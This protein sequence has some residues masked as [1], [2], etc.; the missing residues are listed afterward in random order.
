ME[1]ETQTGTQEEEQPTVQEVPTIQLDENIAK[2]LKPGDKVV[3]LQN[4]YSNNQLLFKANTAYTVVGTVPE[5]KGGF[6]VE[7]EIDNPSWIGRTLNNQKKMQ[8]LIHFESA[9]GGGYLF[10]KIVTPEEMQQYEEQR[11]KQQKG[12]EL[13][14]AYKA[15]LVEHL[16]IQLSH[17]MNIFPDGSTVTY[18]Q[19]IDVSKDVAGRRWEV[20][21]GATKLLLQR[22]CIEPS[23]R[24][25]AYYVNLFQI[26]KFLENPIGEATPQQPQQQQPQQSPTTTS[27]FAWGTVEAGYFDEEEAPKRLEPSIENT[28]WEDY[29]TVIF[30]L[31]NTLW[32]VVSEAGSALSAADVVPPLVLMGKDIVL[33]S[34]NN[35]IRLQR[36]V[37]ELLDLLDKNMTNLGIVSRSELQ[38]RPFESQPAIMLLK[39]F[40]IF[41]YFN[42]E[43]HLKHGME[44]SEYVR[45]LGKT[46]FIDNERENVSNV[47]LNCCSDVMWRGSFRQWSDTLVPRQQKSV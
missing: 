41:D 2:K 11:R 19:I 46:L 10:R 5:R 25:G 23:D 12:E 45:P 7:T 3:V 9:A 21:E 30:D 15:Q 16:A 26:K 28:L 20:I 24:S 40:H 27:S 32:D 8:T 39:K 35:T 6:I 1:E 37:R 17:F 4:R 22:K 43:I 29:D 33:D 14:P 44:K 36:F 13:D 38:N 18:N 47:D 42:Y 31:D 34:Q